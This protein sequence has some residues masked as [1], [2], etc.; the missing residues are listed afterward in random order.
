MALAADGHNANHFETNRSI[1]ATATTDSSDQPA[2]EDI[3]HESPAVSVAST[4]D[5]DNTSCYLKRYADK[6]ACEK[7]QHKAKVRT[8]FVRINKY[9]LGQVVVY[10]GHGSRDLV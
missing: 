2:T 9:K 10:T 4:V 7:Y 1:I 3:S 6:Y 5:I 8:T